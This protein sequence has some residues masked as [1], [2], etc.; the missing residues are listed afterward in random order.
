MSIPSSR[1]ARMAM[2][3]IAGLPRS[4][5]SGRYLAW[6]SA[7]AIPSAAT[8]EPTDRSMLRDTMTSTMPVAMIA[9]TEVCT[10]RFHRLRDVRKAP[11]ESTFDPIQMMS[12][13]ATMPR[14]RVSISADRNRDP[15]VVR[16]VGGAAAG[17]TS[18]G[19][20]AVAPVSVDGVLLISVTGSTIEQLIAK[21]EMEEPHPPRRVRLSHYSW[22][23]APMGRPTHFRARRPCRDRPS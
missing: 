3:Q 2:I 14:R 16:V 11:P 15:I 23:V 17:S 8:I 4:K 6:R 5:I 1:P 20:G 13:A 18:G 9:T 19:G 21:E 10:D 22:S 12:N 7:M